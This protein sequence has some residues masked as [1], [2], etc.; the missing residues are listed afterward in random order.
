MAKRLGQGDEQP[1][2]ARL[3]GTLARAQVDLAIAERE[4]AGAARRAERWAAVA[5]EAATEDTALRGYGLRLAALGALDFPILTMAFVDVAEVSPITA[6]GSA[7]ALSLFLVLGA[8]LLG[9]T[10]R[11]AAG[12]LPS[13]SRAGRHSTGR[14]S[15]RP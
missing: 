4:A 14:H 13:W 11:S 3:T 12:Y 8:H 6:A 1:S 15:D 5:A 7:I 2:E 10:L 9:S